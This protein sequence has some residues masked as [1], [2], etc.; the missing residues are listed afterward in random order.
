[1]ISYKVKHEILQSF[2]IT[3]AGIE[4][5]LED[6]GYSL[7][8]RNRVFSTSPKDGYQEALNILMKDYNNYEER[9]KLPGEILLNEEYIRKI[10]IIAEEMIQGIININTIAEGISRE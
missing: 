1:M 7:R 5:S 8:F 9:A 4:F 2:S 3:V 10:E 6:Y